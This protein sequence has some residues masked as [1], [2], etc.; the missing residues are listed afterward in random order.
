M[1]TQSQRAALALAFEKKLDAALA[2]VEEMIKA[3]QPIVLPE[4]ITEPEEI[5][6]ALGVSLVGRAIIAAEAQEGPRFIQT[7][8]D[9][10]IILL[11]VE[12]VRKRLQLGTAA[13]ENKEVF[14]KNPAQELGITPTGRQLI[15]LPALTGF[16]WVTPDFIK[17]LS[18]EETRAWIGAGTGD[19]E[20]SKNLSQFS[21]TSAE[22]LRKNIRETTGE[23]SL[24]FAKSPRFEGPVTFAD[25]VRQTF[26]PGDEVSGLNVGSH[27]REPKSPSAGD[28]FFDRTEGKFKGYDGFN[29]V[30]LG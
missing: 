12:A 28:I 16:L 4:G 7:N 18:A 8:P 2:G 13:L 23:G 29:W 5:L 21:V 19:A 6:K 20:K 3:A 30:L 22:E 26:N 14:D 15:N 24:V 25:G 11:D 1:I 17:A 9:G 10:S 27:P